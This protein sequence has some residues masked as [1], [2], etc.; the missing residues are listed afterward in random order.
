MLKS[1]DK[2]VI[3][4]LKRQKAHEN[5]KSSVIEII[6]RIIRYKG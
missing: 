4:I 2:D 5:N 3:D 6:L 1:V